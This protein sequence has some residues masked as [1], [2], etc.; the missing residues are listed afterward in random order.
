MLKSYP[1]LKDSIFLN[2]I[3]NLNNKTIYS[4]IIILDWQERR[5]KDIEGRV[6]NGSISVNGDS[7]VRRTANLSV[8]LKD[9]SDLY[10]NSD[11]LF[12]INKKV[13]IEIGIKNTIRHLSPSNYPDFPI[14]WFPFGTFIIQN[15]SLTH[16]LT[17][18][19]LGLTLGDKMCLLNGEAGGTIPASTN[20]ES[21]DTL[22]PDGDLHTENIRINQIIPELINH[23]GGES[24][25]HIIVNDIE[26]KIKQV[27]KWRG[28]NALYI[29]EDKNDP[30]NCFY[31]TGEYDGDFSTAIWT[32]R[33]IIYNYDAGY[34]YVDF[35][36]PGE[37]AAG[38][39][40]TVCT[41]LDKIK[42]ILGNYEY[43]YD[44]FGNFIFQEIKNYINVSEWRT[45]WKNYRQDPNDY[46]PYVYNEKIQ[47]SAF[48]F[49]ND[50][51]ISYNNNPQYNMIK[52]DFIV[53]GTRKSETNLQLPCRYHLAIDKRPYLEENF[54]VT[55]DSF[56][57][58]FD[59]SVD[60]KIRRCF[61]ISGRYA[62]LDELKSERPQGIVGEYYYIT[63]EDA[64]YSW[65]TDINNYESKLNNYLYSATDVNSSTS[66]DTTSES[67]V[68]VNAGYVKME[69]AT[70]YGAGLPNDNFILH[71]NTDWRNI[72]YFRD[73]IAAAQGLDTSYYWAEMYNE[74]PKIY[75]I[76][77]EDYDE[78][79][80]ELRGSGRW[81]EGVL[82]SPSSLDWWLDFIDN[83]AYLNQFNINNIGRRSYAKTESDCN[84]VFE[85]DIPN[86]VIV[87]TSADEPTIV[88]TRSEMTA[89]D[90][91]ELGLH[92]VQVSGSIY[93]SMTMGGSFNSC[94]Q[95]V[96]QLLT[97]YTNYNENISVTC[98]PIYHL[99]PNTRV[100]FND[101]TSGIQGD[102][103]INTISF[104]LS[105][106]GAMNITAKKVIEKI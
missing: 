99:E 86:I 16:D 3:Y 79:T 56:F 19:T 42:S 73:M 100:T 83:N 70:C 38:A 44:V 33:K 52:N 77:F 9:A 106:A 17:G 13:F 47:A 69:L 82:D 105:S 22:G 36:Y 71:P 95:A 96:R 54:S 64:A 103:I 39:G 61:P 48:T 49:T 81:I 87:D 57:I 20:F 66:T 67:T 29:W 101:P 21:Y 59:T 28:S 25:N 1:Y 30:S 93:N 5:I 74:W 37:L 53:W 84:C 76:E 7:A 85:P 43:Y 72:L 12:S 88:D 26:D 55:S 94:Y 65:I 2:K 6:L 50:L 97:N 75:D 23:Y 63:S 45:I 15:S 14:I 92:P 27:M 18:V 58:C 104:D 60:D 68:T 91:K 78:I 41:V 11:S 80:H 51:V 62:T 35:V 40:D 98:V 89:H 46:L 32:K 102:Y 90:L 24:L 31:T 10:S 8:Y 34:T 4:K